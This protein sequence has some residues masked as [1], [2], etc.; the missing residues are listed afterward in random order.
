MPYKNKEEQ[1]RYQ[2]EWI[3]RRRSE[4]LSDKA[5]LDCGA[6]SD[7]E[8]DHL[9]PS[10]KVSHRIWSWETRRREAELAKC[11]VRC[12]GCHLRKSHDNGDL[13]IPKIKVAFEVVEKIRRRYAAGGVTQQQLANE[14]GVNRRHYVNNERRLKF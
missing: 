14:F 10:S 11:V 3:A 8:I 12:R 13:V 7:L 6:T 2:R 4:W 1:R 9:D 5:C